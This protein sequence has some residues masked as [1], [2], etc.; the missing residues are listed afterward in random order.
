MCEF[1]IGLLLGV[2]LNS[3]ENNNG[4]K[5]EIGHGQVLATA[6]HH[7][8]LVRPEVL[9][10]LAVSEEDRLR[11]EDPFTGLWTNIGDHQLIIELSLIHI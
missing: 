9:E 4:F 10:Y 5:W 3:I 8:H 2:F 11:D 1:Y 6:V 7:G